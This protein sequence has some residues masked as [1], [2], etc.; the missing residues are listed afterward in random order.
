MNGSLNATCCHCLVPWYAFV[1]MSVFEKVPEH[2]PI[3]SGSRRTLS[4]FNASI[5]RFPKNGSEL[6]R[7][8]NV[9][10]L[11]TMKSR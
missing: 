1:F 6:Y 2:V 3:A 4:K 9:A 7:A 11:V 8:E 5:S 10:L